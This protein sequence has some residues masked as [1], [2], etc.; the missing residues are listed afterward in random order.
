M[1]ANAAPA[2]DADSAAGDNDEYIVE[3]EVVDEEEK[4]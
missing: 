2:E 1:Y 3:G 4:K